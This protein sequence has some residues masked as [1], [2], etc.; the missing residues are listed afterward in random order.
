MRG[1]VVVRVAFAVAAFALQR[2]RVYVMV[3]LIVLRVL[4]YSL[5]G[6]GG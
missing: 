2:D 1:R 4:L 5:L 6:G 3:T